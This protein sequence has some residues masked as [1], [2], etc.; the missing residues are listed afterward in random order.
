M[1]MRYTVEDL[2]DDRGEMWGLKAIMMGP[3][4]MA[5]ESGMSHPCHVLYSGVFGW[6]AGDV[7]AEGSGFCPFCNQLAFCEQFFHFEQQL[8]TCPDMC[9]A[10]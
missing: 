10:S 5:G 2:N 6:V 9:L 3:L 1:P 4:M 7:G 8:A